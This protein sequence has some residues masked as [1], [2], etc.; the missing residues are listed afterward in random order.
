MPVLRRGRA[1]AWGR[2]RI[3]GNADQWAVTVH[4]GVRGPTVER[5][6]KALA[7][8][9]SLNLVS[10]SVDLATHILMTGLEIHDEIDR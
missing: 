3:W 6:M 10:K 1:G 2:G 7:L 5:C 9:K 8:P 4:N